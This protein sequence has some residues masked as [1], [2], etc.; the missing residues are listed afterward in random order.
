MAEEKTRYSSDSKFE[1]SYGHSR[2]VAAGNLVFVAGTVGYDYETHTISDD[3]AEQTRQT[4]R[5]IETALEA[6]GAKFSDVV[7]IVTYYVHQED[8]DAI[9]SVL[10]EQL[11]DVHPVNAGVQTGLIDP[12]M[13][14]EISAI[15]VRQDGP[16]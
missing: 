13:R 8:W 14:V 4:F 16:S 5:N 2:A 10:K 7:Q 9:G 12:R 1:Q 11:R 6:V 3:P 15:A